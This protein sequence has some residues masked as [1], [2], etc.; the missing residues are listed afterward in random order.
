MGTVTISREAD[1]AVKKLAREYKTSPGAVLGIIVTVGVAR[2]MR[3]H[4]LTL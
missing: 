2:E 4:G 3:K 1:R